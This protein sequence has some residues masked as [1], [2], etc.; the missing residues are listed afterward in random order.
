MRTN[1]GQK[2]QLNSHYSSWHENRNQPV[3]METLQLVLFSYLWNEWWYQHEVFSMF[4]RVSRIEKIIFLSL[5]VRW[6]VIWWVVIEISGQNLLHRVSIFCFDCTSQDRVT[7]DIS[8]QC[9]FHHLNPIPF[10]CV[11]LI[12]QYIHNSHNTKS[13]Q[14]RSYHHTEKNGSTLYLF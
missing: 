8:D 5:P 12:M 14:Q 9:L 13:F 4:R 3:K 11:I 6:Y 10:F 2:W 1:S 7:F